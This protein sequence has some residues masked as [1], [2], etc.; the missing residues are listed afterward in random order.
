MCVQ[1]VC[2]CVCVCVQCL[3]VCLCVCAQ[4]LCVHVC[5]VC[6][7]GGQGVL[8]VV[9][10]SLCGFVGQNVGCQVCTSALDGFNRIINTFIFLVVL[11]T[12]PGTSFVSA[13]FSL[14]Y[15]LR[16]QFK[17]KTNLKR[18]KNITDY[19]RYQRKNPSMLHN[20]LKSH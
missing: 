7:W 11:E 13:T 1:C 3:C 19:H 12:D 14:S 9:G 15:I 17:K 6:V 10:F 2:V 4:C 20:P 5:T 16:S 8:F 18:L